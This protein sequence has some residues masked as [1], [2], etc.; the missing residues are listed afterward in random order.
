MVPA[1]KISA[2]QHLE[3]DVLEVA[4]SLRNTTLESLPGGLLV[5]NGRSKL[6]AHWVT[7]DKI[8]ISKFEI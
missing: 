7:L 8:D 5:C 4:G 2:Y 1:H 3:E 6:Y